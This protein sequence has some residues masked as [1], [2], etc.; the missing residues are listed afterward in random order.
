MR[1]QQT[2][3]R[4]NDPR[5]VLPAVLSPALARCLSDVDLEPVLSELIPEL[6][7]RS[8]DERDPEAA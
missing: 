1:S 8:V 2:S 7:K 3:D 6:P 5:P 4:S